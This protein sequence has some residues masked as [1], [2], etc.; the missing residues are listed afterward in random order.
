MKHSQAQYTLVVVATG[1]TIPNGVHQEL[2]D[3]VVPC[4]PGTTDDVVIDGYKMDIDV[5]TGNITIASLTVTNNRGSDADVVIED[6]IKLTITGNMSFT[7]EDEDDDYVELLIKDDGT[8]VEVQGN[9]V[10]TRTSDNDI[11]QRLRLWLEDLTIADFQGDFTF[12]W[13]DG[14]DEGSDEIYMKNDSRLQI[15]GDFIIYKDGGDDSDGDRF[16]LDMDNEAVLDVTGSMTVTQDGNY[17][18]NIEMS[19]TCSLH[20]ANDFTGTIESGDDFQINL[21]NNAYFDIDGD[22]TLDHNGGDDMV[23]DLDNSSIMN[24]DGDLTMDVD[25]TGSDKMRIDLSTT[26]SLVIDGDLNMIAYAT[27]S[28]ELE[29][30]NTTTFYLGGD[31]TRRSSPNNYGFLD[32]NAGTTVYFVGTSAQVLP[33]SDGASSNILDFQNVVINNTFAT[34]PQLTM[35]GDMTINVAL[36][37]TDG[38]VQSTTGAQF[39]VED[40]ASSNDGSQNSYVD[41]PMTKIGDDDFVFPI[42]KGGKWR[43]MSIDNFSGNSNE[44]E[45]EYFFSA[46]GDATNMVADLDLVSTIEYWNLDRVVDDGGEPELSLYWENADSSGIQDLGD[47]RLARYNSGGPEWES[48]GTGTNTGGIGGASGTAP[49][50]SGISSFGGF[51]FG[52]QGYGNIL[53]IELISFEAEKSGAVVILEWETANEIDNERFELLRSEDGIDF[54]IIGMVK[55]GGTLAGGRSYEYIDEEPLFGSNYYQ[56]RQVDFDDKSE[57]SNIKHINNNLAMGN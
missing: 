29:M 24:V 12:N 46:H 32:A 41:G 3:L 54:E 57:V 26:S 13:L 43:R 42:G 34:S 31:W 6:G 18:V 22:M 44:F 38:I 39:Y 53:P 8:E 7:S 23:I 2:E 30:N 35:E 15:G 49:S 27:G 56:L 25:A 17:D 20:V 1:T 28:C 4:T 37:M 52:S 48:P 10:F 47:L 21:D 9:V 55:G 19:T 16:T 14:D 33:Q 50:A 40:G 36:T 5:N 45:A 11:D 51:T